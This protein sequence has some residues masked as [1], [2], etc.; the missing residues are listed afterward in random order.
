[1]SADNFNFEKALSEL[2]QIVSQMEQGGLSLEESLKSF[3]KGVALTRRCQEALQDAEQKV[4]ILMQ[5]YGELTLDE[6]RTDE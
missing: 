6:Y 2:N 5:N 3:E 1:M 4:H